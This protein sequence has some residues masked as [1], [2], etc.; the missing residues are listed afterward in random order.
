MIALDPGEVRR[1]PEH[2]ELGVGEIAGGMRRR[3]AVREAS[4]EQVERRPAGG[5]LRGEGD[6]RGPLGPRISSQSLIGPSSSA[7]SPST[8]S[9]SIALVIALARWSM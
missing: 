9:T 2:V 4:H 8:R 7:N 1:H 3:G 6:A 5:G